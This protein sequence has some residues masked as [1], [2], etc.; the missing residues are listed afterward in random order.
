MLLKTIAK[1]IRVLLLLWQK[2]RM[3]IGVGIKDQ[4]S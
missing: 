3:D 1:T 2:I 4:R